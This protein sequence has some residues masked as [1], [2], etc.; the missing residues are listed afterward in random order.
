MVTKHTS[1]ARMVLLCLAT[2]LAA[3]ALSGC[4]VYDR[5]PRHAR[6]YRHDHR[7]R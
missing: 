5:G 3:S 2:S 1:L 6:Y 4:Y 7:W